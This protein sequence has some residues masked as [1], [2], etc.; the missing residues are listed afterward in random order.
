MCAIQRG[1]RKK[2]KLRKKD[3]GKGERGIIHSNGRDVKTGLIY[4]DT[5]SGERQGRVKVPPTGSSF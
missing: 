5:K 4:S 3:G 1:K 2:E